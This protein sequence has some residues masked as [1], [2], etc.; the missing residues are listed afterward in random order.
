MSTT[1]VATLS[2][3]DIKNRVETVNSFT[4]LEMTTYKAQIADARKA[5]RARLA[6]LTG[7]QLGTMVEELQKGGAEIRDIKTRTSAKQQTWS[8][9][10]V[11]KVFKSEA[12]QLKAK[13]LKLAKQLNEVEEKYAKV[14]ATKV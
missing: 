13:A 2:N 5:K 4:K 1:Q 12:E 14:T 6:T 7:S 8:I 11:A 9:K 10:L 3:Q